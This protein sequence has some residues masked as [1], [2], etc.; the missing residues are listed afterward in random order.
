MIQE[1]KENYNKELEETKNRKMKELEEREA[2]LRQ[3]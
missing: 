2:K 1:K 3:A